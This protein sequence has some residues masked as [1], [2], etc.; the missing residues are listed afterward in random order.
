MMKK[1]KKTKKKQKKKKTKGKCLEGL[2]IRIDCQ[3]SYKGWVHAWV[4]T[5]A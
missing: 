5:T 3:F 2:E 4:F 1:K